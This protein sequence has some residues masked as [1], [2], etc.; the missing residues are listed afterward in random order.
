M[1]D[2]RAS[3]QPSN[4]SAASSPSY[5][6]PS[7]DPNASPAHPHPGRLPP[8][9]HPVPS[10]S[11]DWNDGPTPRAPTGSRMGPPPLP[12]HIS[13]IPSAAS[14]STNS[15]ASIVFPNR[16]LAPSPQSAS[17]ASTTSLPYAGNGISP[18]TPDSR[19]PRRSNSI[20]A[21]SEDEMIDFSNS[22]DNMRFDGSGGGPL[23]SIAG[24]PKRGEVSDLGNY[25]EAWGQ[26]GL[27]ES[28][29]LVF[30]S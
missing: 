16:N 8:T 28:C 19:L 25:V 2:K 22:M 6:S 15:P 3:L 17:T 21:V 14:S 20:R 4:Y 10:R 24:I 12:N 26:G 9:Q 7:P 23:D 1:T 5:Y 11:T 27:S 18:S 30:K 13:S 29:K